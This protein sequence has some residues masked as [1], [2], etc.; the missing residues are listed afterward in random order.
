MLTFASLVLIGWWLLSRRRRGA[1][2]TPG[3][4]RW[5]YRPMLLLV[6]VP[7]SGKTYK[8]VHLMVRRLAE[9]RHVRTNYNVRHDRVYTALRRRY[10]LGHE[11]ALAAVGRITHLDT[12]EDILDAY[13]C[14]VFIDEAQDL[15]SSTEWSSFPHEVV[16]WFAQHRHRRCR[17]VLASH[18]WG[19]IH[20]YVR[21]LIGD[22][23]LARPAPWWAR[24]VTG[25]VVGAA[26][27]L[28]YIAV[29]DADEGVAPTSGVSAQRSRRSVVTKGE[30]LRLD[31]L[32]ASCYD[33]EGGVRPSPMA[34]I[35]AQRAE[36]KGD[37]VLVLRPRRER[38]QVSWPS[39]GLP[40]LE[41]QELVEALQ[42][43]RSGGGG[44]L[45]ARWAA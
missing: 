44:L 42:D 14:D 30:V 25:A 16:Q 9:G 37:E 6:G 31:P 15:L 21:E 7:G 20:N 2:G 13:D 3:S 17:V 28:Q 5:R 43:G 19:S 34:R 22:I 36:R 23:E 38:L 29:K 45:A 8:M 27:M 10:G 35:R 11:S 32:I 24:A 33:T 41:H 1:K 4:V 18:R 12:F 39:D 26:P 40:Y